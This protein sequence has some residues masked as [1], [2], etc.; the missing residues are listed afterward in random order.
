MNIIFTKLTGCNY[1]IIVHC[2]PDEHISNIIQ[3]Y[4]IKS[5]DTSPYIKFI[6]NAKPFP[7][8]TAEEADLT[9]LAKIIV[10]ENNINK[11]TETDLK[12]ELNFKKK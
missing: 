3:K 4:R 11:S 1:P 12:E 7:F 10:I 2:T 5:G 6:F 9:D 8:I